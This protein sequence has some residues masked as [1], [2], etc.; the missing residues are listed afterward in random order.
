MSRIDCILIAQMTVEEVMFFLGKTDDYILEHSYVTEDESF[1]SLNDMFV[2]E[3]RKKLVI[4]YNMLT[5][6]NVNFS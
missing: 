2:A 6:S 5:D 1:L 4:R 3:I